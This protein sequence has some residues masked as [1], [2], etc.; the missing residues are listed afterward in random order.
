MMS[1]GWT[2]P[3]VASRGT[4]EILN[5]STDRLDA[6]GGS[7]GALMTRDNGSRRRQAVVVNDLLTLTA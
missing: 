4:G 2:T 5:W 3:V 6:A 7:E 1:L